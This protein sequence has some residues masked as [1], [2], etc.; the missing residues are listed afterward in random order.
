MEL[1]NKLEEV[2]SQK[3]WKRLMSGIETGT[4]WLGWNIRI[5]AML[6]HLPQFWDK[7]GSKEALE[8]SLG[9]YRSIT[10]ESSLIKIFPMFSNQAKINT[11]FQKYP[12]MNRN[13]PPHD[14]PNTG[15]KEIMDVRETRSILTRDFIKSSF[16]LLDLRRS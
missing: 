13:Y 7:E 5:Y 14:Q 1:R 8:K 6:V 15:S 10:Q 16:F 2:Q 11:E 9:H 4:S 3:N 12:S